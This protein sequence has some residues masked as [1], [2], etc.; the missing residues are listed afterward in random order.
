MRFIEGSRSPTTGILAFPPLPPCS[1]VTTTKVCRAALGTLSLTAAGAGFAALFSRRGEIQLSSIPLFAVSGGSVYVAWNLKDYADAKE[2]NAMREK[3]LE[4]PFEKIVEEH[5]LD[6]VVKHTVVLPSTLQ[7]K[8]ERQHAEAKLSIVL[9]KYPFS[10]IKK[11]GLASMEYLSKLLGAELATMDVKNLE[12]GFVQKCCREEILDKGVLDS[13]EILCDRVQEQFSSLK[14]R[15]EAID[16]VYPQRTDRLLKELDLEEAQ[17]P[18][19]ALDIAQQVRRNGYAATNSQAN[20]QAVFDVVFT[21]KSAGTIIFERMDRG[22]E[23]QAITDRAAGQTA[24]DWSKIERIKIEAKKEMIRQKN[25]GGSDQ[26]KY[27]AEVGQ[28][29]RDC[30]AEMAN[31]QSTFK[32]TVASLQQGV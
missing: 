24:E 29:K 16:I 32:K 5:G 18:Q 6:N 22:A 30:E 27:N 21:R 26:I 7:S 31:I 10:D 13:L 12:K 8:F 14:S 25:M 9:Q 3:A 28:A 19:K 2:L 11:Y 1:A 17:I 23:G 15:Y 4:L 20:T